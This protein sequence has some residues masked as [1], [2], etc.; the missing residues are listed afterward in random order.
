M[1]WLQ[2]ITALISQNL[3]NHTDCPSYLP[4]LA[5]C[6]VGYPTRQQVVEASSGRSLRLSG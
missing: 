4:E 2:N 3:D 6:W 1:L 5:P